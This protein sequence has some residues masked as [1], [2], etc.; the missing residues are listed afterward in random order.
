MRGHPIQRWIAVAWPA[1]LVA[2][3]LEMLVFAFVNPESLQTLGGATLPL[4]PTA[5]YSIAF[6][7][8]WACVALA[9]WMTLLLGRG[10]RAINAVSAMD[11]PPGGRPL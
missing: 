5:I 1:F 2:G 6:L 8:F 11:G 10:A 7:L 3:L 4:S 9:C